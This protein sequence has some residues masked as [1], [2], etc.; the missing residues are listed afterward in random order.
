MVF[1]DSSSAGTGSFITGGGTTSDSNGGE[2]AFLGSSTAANGT[3]INN[4]GTANQAQ[5]GFVEFLDANATAGD[6]TFINNGASQPG[7]FGG[8]TTFSPGDPANSTLIANG[9]TNGGEG[10]SILLTCETS[11]A[12]PRV[13]VFGN[14]TL[15][16]GGQC[17][18]PTITVGSLEGDGIVAMSNFPLI[19]GLN[20]LST[21]FA[22]SMIDISPFGGGTLIKTGTGTLIL[23]GANRYAGGTKIE[24]G[25]LEVSNRRGSGTGTGPVHVRRGSIGGQGAIAGDVTIG[26]DGGS[27]ASLAPGRV[28]TVPQT[29]TILG[30][31]TLNSGA[32]YSC[33]INSNSAT[34]DKVVSNGV[35]INGAA[36]F[37]LAD[38]GD[39][40]LASGTLLTVISNPALAPI[41][42]TFSNLP[43]GSTITAG[44]NT[45]Q[46]NYEGGDGNDLT[47]TVVP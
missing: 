26:T 12:S 29:L 34:A 30:S 3:F 11:G 38:S 28:A 21:T 24:K 43:D 45:F 9:G 35:T 18:D 2:V 27:R 13:E 37:S 16:L 10:G 39:T 7:A 36:L 20:N 32:T 4:P 40:T 25:K 22:G 15:Y 6:A 14:G 17:N 33:G 42:G 23:T 47:L 5:G 19:I 1:E 41:A 31:L 46:A 8:A 44:N